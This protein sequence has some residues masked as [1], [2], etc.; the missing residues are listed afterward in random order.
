M[1]IP[2]TRSEM[3]KRGWD[4]LDVILVSGDTYIDS[5]FNGTALIGHWLIENGFRV[6]IICQ[7][8]MGSDD[9]IGRLGEPELFWSISAGCVDS[10]VAN[11]TPTLKF[12]KDDDFTPGGRNDRRPDRACIAYTNLIKRFHK[13]RPIVLGGVEASLRRVVHYDFWSDSLRRSIL[14]DAK[15]DIIMLDNMTDEMTA[16][17]VAMAKGKAELEAS[18]NMSIERLKALAEIGVDYISCGALTHSAPILD[19]SM[20]NLKPIE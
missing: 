9:D 12:R 1:F 17:A 2:T 18:G 14:F 4:A 8:D 10:M 11:Y 7:P 15:A 19:F 20:K 16:Q 5:S 3:E 13:G 6:G